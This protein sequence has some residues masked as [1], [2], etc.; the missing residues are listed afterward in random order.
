MLDS[1]YGD[2][3]LL[4]P[5][6][7]F[8]PD[9]VIKR[10]LIMC[11]LFFAMLFIAVTATNTG[12]VN[13]S[14][15]ESLASLFERLWSGSKE[16]YSAGSS[17][18]LGLRLPR[19]LMALMSGA[20]LAA[21]GVC[22]QALFRNP[23]ADPGLIGVSGG[24]AM[25]ASIA[26]V[27]GASVF[28]GFFE[29]AGV[30][31]LPFCAFLGALLVTMLIYGFSSMGGQIVTAYLLLAGI[32][33]NS[34][35]GVIIGMLTYLSDDV[36]L[37]DLTFWSMGSL[38]GMTWESL[39][40]VMLPMCLALAFMLSMSRVLNLIQLG[41]Q[42]ARHLG[43]NVATV[44]LRILCSVA[45]AVGSCVA[46]TGMIG[47]VGLVV[48]HMMRLMI[49]A[50]HKSLLPAS[51]LL[52]ASVMTLADLLARTLVTPAEVP[53]GLVTSAIGAPFFLWLLVKQQRSNNVF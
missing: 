45:V 26:I 24:A 49:G 12:A 15:I 9:S 42:G 25:G 36:Q 16:A 47:F 23:L 18:V 4:R 51:M 3:R 37:R 22:L 20:V 31:V 19:V 1:N 28:P 6:T 48:P 30:Y 17:I 8:D 32:A 40:I 13:Y 14:L 5:L 34:L 53:I 33:I 50:N 11:V 7:G 41:E 43:M 39:I 2:S 10:R 27:L 46:F 21:S 35:S 52:G 44:K 29:F 38:G